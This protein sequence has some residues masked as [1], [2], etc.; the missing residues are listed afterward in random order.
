ME[1][2]LPQ[3]HGR[4]DEDPDAQE[5]KTYKSLLLRMGYHPETGK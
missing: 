5:D 4:A 1:K 2:R 3:F